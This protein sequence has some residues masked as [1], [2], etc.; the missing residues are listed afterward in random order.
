MKRNILI[1]SVIAIVLVS[2]SYLST[3]SASAL[4]ADEIQ[5]QIKELLAKVADLTRQLNMLQGQSGSTVTVQPSTTGQYHRVCG[6]LARSLAQGAHGDD[7]VSLQEFLQSE[8]YLSASATGYYGPATAQAVA[9]WQASQGLSAVGVIGPMSRER[10]KL[11]CGGTTGS[12]LSASPSSGPAPLAVSFAYQ[13]KEE[14]AQ[15]YIE[16]GDGTGQ[17]MNT[18]QIYCIRAPCISPSTASHTYTSPGSYTATVSHY[19]ACLYTNPRCMIAQ[20]APLAHTT[21]TVRATGSGGAPVISSFSGPTTLTLN[22]QG[23]WKISASDPENSSLTYSIIWGDEWYGSNTASM[24]NPSS[25]VIQETTFTHSYS[26]AGSYKVSVTV[27]D[28]AANEAHATI[29]VRVDN[30]PVACTADYTPVCGRPPG[31]AN[32][33]PPGMYCTLVCRLHDPVTYSNKCHLSAAGAEYLY[34]GACNAQ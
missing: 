21:I 7:V 20:P 34:A 23:T 28:N 30:A 9:R 22:E 31:C 2:S 3:P 32:T 33:C 26:R 24:T 4:T 12:D 19:I 5:A 8:G 10:I 6:M 14:N 17:V 1:A 15:Y 27:R 18:Q 16:F 11:W 29:T 25:S 13:P